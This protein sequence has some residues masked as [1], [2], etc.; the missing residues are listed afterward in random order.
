MKK[1]YITFILI[2]TAPAALHAGE[3]LNSVVHL[4]FGGMYSFAAGGD[5]IDREKEAINGPSG[6]TDKSNISHYDTAGCAT[7]DIVPTSPIII[8]MEENA[9]KFGIRSSYRIQYVNQRVTT[10]KQEVGNKVMDY[11][12]W[13]IGPIIYYA[14]FI[15]PSDLNTDYTAGGGFTLYALY[16][17]LNGHLTAFPS[18]REKDLSVTAI[19]STGDYNTRIGGSKM[20][21]GIGAEFSLCSLNVGV[22]IYYTYMKLKMDEK[23]YSGSG[24][25]SNIKEGCM[26]IY[27]GIPVESFIEPLLPKF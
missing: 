17:Q 16:G 12:S 20:D 2:L 9:F 11:K 26:E 8:G 5:L 7:L 10:T 19:N 15:G 1:L 27:V 3:F 21:F 14:P 23:I 24:K 6:I 13:M 18:I 25:K 22:N 4:N